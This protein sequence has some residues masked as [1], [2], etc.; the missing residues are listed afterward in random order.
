MLDTD[1]QSAPLFSSKE[2]GAL[3][4]SFGDLV[5]SYTVAF[6]AAKTSEIRGDDV[7]PASW[8]AAGP[9]VVARKKAQHG[10]RSGSEKQLVSAKLRKLVSGGLRR[11][12]THLTSGDT[13]PNVK[14][15]STL[16]AASEERL[17]K[18]KAKR[19]QT[20][21]QKALA[22]ALSAAKKLIVRRAVAKKPR[23]P[24]VL[25]GAAAAA[26]VASASSSSTA[27]AQQ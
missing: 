7:T 15:A 5:P 26:A 20:A 10:G 21:A 25:K 22:P 12:V 23:A 11:V 16:A 1:L 19:A 14:S 18:A 24:R 9:A 2:D 4:K 8:T 13:V 17:V 27:A 6:A 3:I